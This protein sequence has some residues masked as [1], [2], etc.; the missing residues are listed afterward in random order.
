[1]YMLMCSIYIFI[2]MAFTTTIIE[3]VRRQYAESWRLGQGQLWLDS[4]ISMWNNISRLCLQL[5][6]SLTLCCKYSMKKEKLQLTHSLLNRKMV[7]LRAQ[8]Q[9]KDIRWIFC[10]K[11]ETEHEQNHFRQQAHD[12]YLAEYLPMVNEWYNFLELIFNDYFSFDIGTIK[13]GG[14]IEK[15]DRACR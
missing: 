7:E 2:G 11:Y 6:I 13:S 15:T 9:V 14:N 10:L 4:I 3:L 5:L 12:F 8:I 1:M